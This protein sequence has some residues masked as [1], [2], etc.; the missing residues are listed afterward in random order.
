MGRKALLPRT[1]GALLALC[2]LCA[3]PGFAQRDARTPDPDPELERRSFQV[4]DGFEVNLFAADPLLAKPIEM[5][6]DAS[7]RLWVACSEA[8]PQIKPGQKADDKIVILEDTKGAGRADRTT[9]Y[10]GGLLIPT[11][12]E[13]GDGGCYVVDSTDLL[14]LGDSGA[15]GAR[16]PRK[17]D[18]RRVVLS[19]FGTEDTHHLVHTLRWGPDGMLYFNQS[20]YIHSH[21][22]TPYGPRRLGGGGVWQFRPETLR[23]EVFTRGLINP[24]GHAFDRWGQSF[25]TDGAGGEGINYLI[26]GASYE[27]TPGAPR[28]V[29]GLNPGSPKYCG[30]EAVSGRHFPDSWQGNLVT[31]DFRGHRVCRFVVTPDGSGYAARE[32]PEV[33]KTNHGAFRPVDVKMG[34]DGALYV[35]DWYNP[36]IQHGEVDFR[37]PRRDI[38]HGRIWRVTAKG[39]PLVARPRLVAAKTEEMLES[40]KAPEDWT[41]HFAR[42]VLKE[43]GAAAVTPAL[44]AWAAKLGGEPDRLEALWT[45]QALDVVEPKLLGS[46]L[47]ARDA[48]VR[49]AAVRV[50]G[51]WRD[52]LA[53]PLVLL[54]PRAADEAPRVRLEAVRALGGIPSARSA[55]LALAA[56]D[57]PMDRFLDYGLWLTCRELTPEWLPALEQ[58]KFAFGNVRRLLFALQAAGTPEVVRPLVA[59]IRSGKL[60]AEGEDEALGL[61][62]GQGGPDELAML[63]DRAL[64]AGAAPRA[65]PLAALGQA[66]RQRRV[67]PS[68]DLGRVAPLWKADDDALRAEAFRVSGLWGL[69]EARPALLDAARAAG[70]GPALR[71]AAVE[72]LAALGGPAS[73]DALD[74]LA[75]GGP[76]AARRAALAGLVSVDAKAAAARAADVLALPG[77]DAEA[78]AVFEA[79]LGRKEGAALLAAGLAGKKLPADVAKVGVR[80][81]GAS[82]R[83]TGA[84]AEA[85]KRAGGL[86]GTGPRV[87]NPDEMKA[88]VEEVARR[89]DPARGEAV[90]RRADL[91]CLKCHA[92]SGAGGRVGPDLSSIGAS[93]P[94]DYL[95]D[96]LLQPS[97]AIK[98]GYHAMLVTT[99]QGRTLTG[100]KVREAGGVLVLRDAEDREV[101]VPTA[102]VDEREVSKVSLMPE[103]LADQ[104]TRGELVDL[105]R[106]LSELGK[107]GP[108]SVTKARL[109]RR[110]EALQPTPAAVRAL[111]EGGPAA[112]MKLGFPGTWAPAYATVAGELPPGELPRLNPG[113]GLPPLSVVRCQLDV[114]GSAGLVLLRLGGSEG[115]TPWVDGSPAPAGDVAE[116]KLAAGTHTLTFVVDRNARRRPLRCEVDDAPGSPARATPVGGK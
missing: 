80:L 56:L 11:G 106:F 102:D 37:D 88:L 87:L 84:L 45:Y 12:L 83:D 18:R 111:G 55:E 89:G 65:R 95:V 107:V 82:G 14:H 108:Y 33:I 30:L 103:G 50:A 26:P 63:L 57:R 34:P 67:R 54:G 3:A 48:R 62:A 66:A 86:T 27:W 101:E 25:G 97:K 76:T 47:E 32:M 71:Q 58:G 64:A 75:A 90:F 29:H 15:S 99:K 77:G 104:L 100:L 69:E 68:G 73:R 19:G 96:S 74:K 23:L 70:T 49:A 24:W 41:R 91:S 116:V 22:E 31:N 78:R 35:A 21:I 44:A 28:I 93:A 85:L 40:L 105:V 13:P 94:V 51:A 98:E 2:A 81:A 43:R 46:L 115:L 52:R 8:Y 39:R 72:G 9:V 60:D 112:A 92:V 10:A 16:L 5:N 17:A 6:F 113:N 4:A 114:S 61:I 36:I 53:D 38:S 20:T 110:W 1:A 7:G 42:R 59:L 109:V 79:F